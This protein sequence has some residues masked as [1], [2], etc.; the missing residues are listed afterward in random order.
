[1]PRFETIQAS[2]KHHPIDGGK[3]FGHNSASGF[4]ETIECY[5]AFQPVVHARALAQQAILHGCETSLSR[6]TLETGGEDM[7]A[8]YQLIPRKGH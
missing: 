3:R 1:M 7:P 5:S 6:Q 2:G 8:G 4:T